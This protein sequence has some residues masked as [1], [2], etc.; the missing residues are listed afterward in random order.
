M[1]YYSMSNLACQTLMLIVPHCGSFQH[2]PFENI[3]FGEIFVMSIVYLKQ[4]V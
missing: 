1:L 4:I 2:A 3:I